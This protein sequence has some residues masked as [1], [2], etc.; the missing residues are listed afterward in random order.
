MENLEVELERSQLKHG[1][2]VTLQFDSK[3]FSGVIDFESVS[4]PDSPRKEHPSSPTHSGTSIAK[5]NR[6]RR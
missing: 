6:D 3:M 1:H 5:G 2:K 4:P